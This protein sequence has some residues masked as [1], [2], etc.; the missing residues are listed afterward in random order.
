MKIGV[1]RP[2]CPD[3]ITVRTDIDGGTDRIVIQPDD[4]RFRRRRTHVETE[5]AAVPCPG[6]SLFRRFICD[7]G[8]EIFQRGKAAEDVPAVIEKITQPG[9]RPCFVFQGPESAAQGFEN[10]GLPGDNELADLTLQVIH[11]DGV[12]RA[13]SDK[14]DVFPGNMGQEFRDL[15]RHHL[16]EAGGD[17][18]LGN[19]LVRRVGAVALAENAAAAGNP[20]GAFRPGVRHGVIQGN[21]DSPDLL[22]KKLARSRGAFVSR[23]NGGDF[24]I[25]AQ[26]INQKGFTPGADNGVYVIFGSVKPG[27]G[28]FHGLRLGDGCQINVFPEFSARYGDALIGGSFDFFEVFEDVFLRVAVMGLR[29]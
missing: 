28:F 4:D 17:T 3:R 14:Q 11:H 2:G 29:G 9:K 25:P 26:N 7:H 24:S 23:P 22:E 27:Q 19:S 5:N 21:S 10:G 8:L 1:T 18:A 15:S 20:V 6:L 16:A 13:A 12:L